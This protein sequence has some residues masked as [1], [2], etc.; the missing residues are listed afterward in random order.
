MTPACVC[1]GGNHQTHA[2]C[3]CRHC[4][5]NCWACRMLLSGLFVYRESRVAGFLF[6]FFLLPKSLHTSCWGC[7]QSEIWPLCHFGQ[8]GN[9]R[10]RV[11]SVQWRKEFRVQGLGV[12]ASMLGGVEKDFV[13]DRVL[14]CPAL[15]GLV[16]SFKSFYLSPLAFPLFHFLFLCWKPPCDVC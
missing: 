13:F 1:W 15:F 3:R 14:A 10:L 12:G 7:R 8:N 2:G 9:Q 11:Y 5:G 16:E 4:T 6:P